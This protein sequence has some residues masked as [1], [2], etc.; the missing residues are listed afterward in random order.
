MTRIP[1][2]TPAS[3]NTLTLNA[4]SFVLLAQQLADPANNQRSEQRNPRSLS[5]RIQPLDEDFLPDGE[6]FWTV[7]RDISTRGLGFIMPEPIRHQYLNVGLG[8]EGPMAIVEVRHC[9]SIGSEYPLYLIGVSFLPEY[10][11]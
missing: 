8:N 2:K 6:R 7:S 11:E 5:L 9:S 4:I 3:N 1:N 10:F